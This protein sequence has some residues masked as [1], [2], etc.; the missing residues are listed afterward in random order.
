VDLLEIRKQ[1]VSAYYW[2]SS[3]LILN[4]IV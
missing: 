4:S 1:H 3:D 2:P